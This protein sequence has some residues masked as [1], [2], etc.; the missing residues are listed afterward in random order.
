MSEALSIAGL[1]IILI[2]LVGILASNNWRL[3]I[4]LLSILYLGCFLL[5]LKSLPLVLA[6]S[7]LIAGWIAGVILGMVLAG[8]T[9]EESKA[10]GYSLTSKDSIFSSHRIFRLLLAGIVILVI[11]SIIGRFQEF[12]P[13]ISAEQSYA[14]AM[15]IGLSLIL[16]SLISRP[17]EATVGLLI[18]LA[19]FEILYTVVETSALVIGLLT[20]LDLGL[21]LAGAY[22]IVA[23]T[24][25]KAV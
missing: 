21:A 23:P 18:L 12:V 25:E 8:L 19:G 13:G 7:K 16:L 1:V 15:M 6:A 5:L 2:S 3:T 17:F 10:L 4:L 14:S 11:I 20:V 22:L 24:I 9:P